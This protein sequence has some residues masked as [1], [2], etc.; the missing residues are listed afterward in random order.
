MK[1]KPLGERIVIK[2]LES[3]EKTKSGIVLP[4]TAKEK[5][6]MG[7][8]LAVGSGKTLDNGQKVPMEVKVGDKILFAKYAGTEVKV[9]GEE[10][11]VLKESDVLAI[12]E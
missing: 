3:E 1:I 9:D 6:Q 7:E 4:D 10:Y 12:L 5:P 8:V 2:V 11:M